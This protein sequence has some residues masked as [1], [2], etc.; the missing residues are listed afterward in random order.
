MKGHF[1][2]GP[3]D[4]LITTAGVLVVLHAL[5]V[6]AGY[7]ADRDSS[8]LRATGKVLAAFTLSD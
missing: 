4:I 5:R 6:A 2:T 7:L 1:H 3:V 8:Y